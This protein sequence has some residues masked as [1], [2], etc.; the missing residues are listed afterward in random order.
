M[1]EVKETGTITV[2]MLEGPDEG[3]AVT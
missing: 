3:R 1:D 2:D